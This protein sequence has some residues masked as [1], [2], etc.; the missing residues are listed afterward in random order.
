MFSHNHS[1]QRVGTGVLLP[2]TS[3]HVSSNHKIVTFG[4]LIKT[5]H[6][7]R[8]YKCT[9]AE[10]LTFSKFLR[11]VKLS[12]SLGC[13]NKGRLSAISPNSETRRRVSSVSGAAPPVLARGCD[14]SHAAASC[15]G[16]LTSYHSAAANH[17]K[18]F[19]FLRSSTQIFFQCRLHLKKIYF[20]DALVF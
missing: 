12:S 3:V 2:R 1:W 4:I 13:S 8:M 10:L 5:A 11:A 19:S 6:W 17:F 7:N 9:N 20:L 18:Y 16:A 15:P 14:S